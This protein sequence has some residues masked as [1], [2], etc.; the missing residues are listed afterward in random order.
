VTKGQL[1]WKFK[2]A[3]DFRTFV[4]KLPLKRHD[5]KGTILPEGQG[6]F[7]MSKF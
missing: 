2:A 4:V 7:S 1:S 3:G 5:A 6:W